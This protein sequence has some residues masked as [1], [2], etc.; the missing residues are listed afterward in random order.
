M[1]QKLSER[2]LAVWGRGKLGGVLLRAY[3][4]QGLFSAKRVTATVKPGEKA[5]AL[6]KELGVGVT[7]DNRKAVHGADIVVLG[8]AASGERS[9][10][11][12]CA[13]VA[14][15]DAG[16]FGRCVVPTTYIEQHA[17]D[18]VPVVRAMPSTC[19][20][21]GSGMSGICRGT[22]AKAEHL[23]AARAMFDGWGEPL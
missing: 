5:A 2:R 4:A 13:G 11:R 17:G 22:H 23:E 10:E 6:A 19:S 16:G 15:R 7:T 21:V 8:E 18:E 14:C 20:R 3:L 9:V 12:D 1:A